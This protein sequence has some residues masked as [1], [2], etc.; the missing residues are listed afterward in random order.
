M[1]Y[2][3]CTAAD[4]SRQ[5]WSTKRCLG[6]GH[7]DEHL[8]VL[9]M[10]DGDCYCFD[11]CPIDS[12]DSRTTRDG[13]AFIQRAQDVV[14]SSPDS[15]WARYLNAVYNGQAQ[16]P[17]RL[18]R[19]TAFYLNSPGWRSKHSNAPNP[20][21]DC[22]RWNSQWR[23]ADA[24]NTWEA[25]LPQEPPHCSAL[26]N[27]NLTVYGWNLGTGDRGLRHVDE[28]QELPLVQ[29]FSADDDAVSVG[30]DLAPAHGWIEIMRSDARPYFEEAMRPPACPDWSPGERYWGQ[31]CW[32]DLH[33]FAGGRFPP[34][35][36]ARPAVGTG[37]WINVNRTR[38]VHNLYDAWYSVYNTSDSAYSTYEAMNFSGATGPYWPNA[39]DFALYARSEG[40]DTLQF[41]LGDRWYDMQPPL[42]L[43]TSETCIGRHEPLRAC[44]DT[45]VRAGWANLPCECD[46]T[47]R[48]KPIDRD[49]LHAVEVQGE[50]QPPHVDYRQQFA[51]A[52]NINCALLP[53]PPPTPPRPPRES[54]PPV[55]PPCPSVPP[56]SPSSPSPTLP[57][58]PAAPSPP[59]SPPSAPPRLPPPSLPLP[60]P[61]SSADGL[62]VPLLAVTAATSAG[63]TA[64]FLAV[65]ATAMAL[66]IIVLLGRLRGWRICTANR[67]PPLSLGATRKADRRFRRLG[68]SDSIDAPGKLVVAPPGIELAVESTSAAS[69]RSGDPDGVEVADGGD[70]EPVVRG[71]KLSQRLLTV[72][73]CSF[74]AGAAMALAFGRMTR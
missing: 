13:A 9:R 68:A 36:W 16:L 12:P 32:R 50:Q 45:E 74:A 52:G 59:R 46:D 62:A 54:P 61:P 35:C 26:S 49:F 21:R 63:F 7:S 28:L 42:L 33:T 57:P 41:T 72:G 1:R 56:A 69:P 19:L 64:P 48:D 39:V 47:T 10:A 60:L 23:C 20:F 3:P 27:S 58:S 55:L 24:C 17:M 34:G 4:G 53:L 11:L 40:I 38:H 31:Q 30:R 65:T 44:L 73:L 37:V 18:G 2:D 15:P 29:V 6:G 5:P 66:L 8:A 25:E 70:S 22:I 71:H 67:A 14:I 43:V 51:S